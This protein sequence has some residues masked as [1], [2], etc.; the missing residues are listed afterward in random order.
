MSVVIPCYNYGHFLPTAVESVVTQEGVDVD[1]LI[2]DDC[3]TDDSLQVAERLAERHPS[4]RVHRNEKN[5]GLI[6][7]ANT[8]LAGVTG[9]YALLISADDALAPG[10]LARAAALMDANPDVGLTYGPVT[11]STGDELP[12]DV[13][14]PAS[15]W[16]IWD[17]T[18]WAARLF[19]NGENQ[20]YSPEA[21]VRTST[22]RE[23]GDYDPTVPYTSDLQMWL[24]FA[25]QGNVGF[26]AGTVQAYYRVHGGN[27]S[28]T[29]GGM[30]GDRRELSELRHRMDAFES[31][32]PSF[33]HGDD[34][35]SHA[36]RAVARYA[37]LLARIERDADPASDYIDELVTFAT[38]LDP[39]SRRRAAWAASR[40]RRVLAS[41]LTR[42]GVRRLV[43]L[44]K[45]RATSRRRASNDDTGV[46]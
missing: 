23:V 8:G 26:I 10:A 24:R 36:R 5:L 34:Y 6:G 1:V 15:H 43:I 30:T 42:T 25:A 44:P 32:A 40:T 37:L 9:T 12:Q 11:Y 33:A 27:M 35:L 39:S 28:L 18:D 16:V 19:E 17:G 14:D 31:A 7:T 2:I 38:T 22:M 46:H 3:S 21:I 41:A 29:Q 13:P 45:I 4:V 20:I